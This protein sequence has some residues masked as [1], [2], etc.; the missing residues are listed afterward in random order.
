[1]G[2]VTPKQKVFVGEYI[3][4][5]NGAEAIRRA[6]Y[7]AS[8]PNSLASEY[9]AKPSIQGELRRQLEKSGLTDEYLDR[10]TEKLIDSGI[11]NAKWT[12]PAV[13]LHA[14][15]MVNKLKD[16]FPAQKTLTASLQ[17]TA[18]L[19]GKDTKDLLAMLE[20]IQLENKKLADKIKATKALP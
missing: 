16:R 9:L 18:E 19:E 4:T 14:I 20:H 17:V 7:H 15:E 12:K 10:A 2:K 6:G 8:Q 1:M 3:K 5:K 13:A 11:K